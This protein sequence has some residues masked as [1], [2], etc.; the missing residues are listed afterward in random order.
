[1]KRF[2][3]LCAITLSALM[4]APAM[5]NAQGITNI[6]LV[7]GAFADGSS[8]SAVIERLQAKGYH[9]T[10]VQN[11]LTSLQ[12]DVD[13]TERVIA[14]QHGDVL[15]VGHSWAGAVRRIYVSYSSS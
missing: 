5:V 11:P 14:R 8:W 12:N 10:A 3:S 9:V 6:V 13:A 4:S 7:H 2:R 15:L 1:M